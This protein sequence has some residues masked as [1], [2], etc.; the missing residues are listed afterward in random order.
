MSVQFEPEVLL[1][2][3]VSAADTA[4]FRVIE[5]GSVGGIPLLAAELSPV[6]PKMS[7]YLSAGIHG[8][9]PAGTL[10]LFTLMSQRWFDADIAW[11]VLPLLNPLGMK[12][13][14][15]EAPGG[16]DLNRD[17]RALRAPET[18]AHKAW[19]SHANSRYDVALALHE[20]WESKGFYL[21]ELLKPPCPDFGYSILQA[22]EP[23]IDIDCSPEID[24][25]PA[26]NGLLRPHADDSLETVDE[27][28]EQ[29]YL[30][31]NNTS[32][33]LTFETPSSFPIES[34]VMA[35]VVAVKTAIN[36]LLAP[37][38]ENTFEI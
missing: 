7:V 27:W 15:R 21:Y 32:A 23:V 18:R 4:G 20:D 8:D 5:Y 19:I 2:R 3:F 22:V 17:Y 12:A 14:T 1:R 16:I 6:S 13:G 33:S 38:I 24:G 28:P 34:R 25:F 30:R 35:H 26:R 29:L 9:E 31:Q 36:L 10:A 37:R 11:H